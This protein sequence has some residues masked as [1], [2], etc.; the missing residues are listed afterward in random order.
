MRFDLEIKEYDPINLG[1]ALQSFN[2]HKWIDAMNEEMKSVHDNDVWDLVRLP[3]RLKPIGCKW[4]FKTKRDSKGNKERY[5]ARL[6]A[7]GFTQRE[8]IDY[9]ESFFFSIIKGFIQI[10]NGTSSSF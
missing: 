4:I 2:A 6:V 10:H 7:K 5:K 1:Q 9:N 3:E 8:G